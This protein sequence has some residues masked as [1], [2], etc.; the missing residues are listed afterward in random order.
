M[1]A[2]SRK[3]WVSAAQPTANSRFSNPLANKERTQSTFL[4]MP[5]RVSVTALRLSRLSAGLV[6]VRA[7]SRNKAQ[8]KGKCRVAFRKMLS[9]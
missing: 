5:I 7:A 9:K 8:S 3:L 1:R 6:R 4:K 2:T